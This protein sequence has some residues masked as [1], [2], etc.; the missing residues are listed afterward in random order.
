M[1]RAKYACTNKTIIETYI[2][3]A[4]VMAC[5]VLKTVG[6][7]LSLLS[8]LF[9]SFPIRHPMDSFLGKKKIKKVFLINYTLPA[10][11]F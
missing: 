4:C 11:I 8:F 3:S 2:L 10:P 7:Y 9:L 1:L 6:F 5:F